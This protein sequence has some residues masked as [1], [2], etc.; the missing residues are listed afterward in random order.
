MTMTHLVH[1]TPLLVVVVRNHTRVKSNRK[2]NLASL[3]YREWQAEKSCPHGYVAFI[4]SQLV[5]L[6]RN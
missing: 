3:P 5:P 2:I 1:K 4:D 6:I